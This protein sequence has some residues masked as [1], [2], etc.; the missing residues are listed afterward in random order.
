LVIGVENKS[1]SKD[2]GSNNLSNLDKAMSSCTELGFSKGT[3]KHGDCV[4]KL[5]D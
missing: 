4:L 2:L 3:E 1:E 5:L